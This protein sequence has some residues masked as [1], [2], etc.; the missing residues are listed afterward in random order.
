VADAAVGLI[1]MTGRGFV[2]AAV[3][4]PYIIPPAV[5]ALKAS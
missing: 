1:M 2:R 4:I 5:A 3:V